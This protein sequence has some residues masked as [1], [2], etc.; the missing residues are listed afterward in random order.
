MMRGGRV[1][2]VAFVLCAS[3]STARAEST[4]CREGALVETGQRLPEVLAH[5]GAPSWSQSYDVPARRGYLR[6][7]EWVYPVGYGY[8]PRLLRFENGVL[9]RVLLS[10]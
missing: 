5:C 10:R 3:A 2:G 7:D 1:V 8:F 9:V 4:I 6:V